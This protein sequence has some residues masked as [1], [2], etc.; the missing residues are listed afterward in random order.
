M[1]NSSLEYGRAAA[2]SLVLF[3]VILAF[4]MVQRFIQRKW[5]YD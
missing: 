5:T 3:A 1:I 2:A 4:T